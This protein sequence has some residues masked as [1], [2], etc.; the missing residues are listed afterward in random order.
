M[1]LPFMCLVVQAFTK[2]SF[3]ESVLNTDFGSFLINP[4][5]T[6]FG[7]S[8]QRLHPSPFG[9]GQTN[10]NQ[11]PKRNPALAWIN[12]ANDEMFEKRFSKRADSLFQSFDD[13]DHHNP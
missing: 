11:K 13:L 5:D 2:H 12:S 10:D 4:W 7:W 1:K 8:K 9:T 6:L 3:P